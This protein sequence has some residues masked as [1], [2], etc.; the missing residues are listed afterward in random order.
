LMDRDSIR[1][2]GALAIGPAVEEAARVEPLRRRRIGVE[3]MPA[4]EMI[5]DAPL[6]IDPVQE[7]RHQG[8][9]EAERD[10]QEEEEGAEP[11]Q[12]GSH[13]SSP[14]VTDTGLGTTKPPP[15]FVRL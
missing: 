8:R 15:H 14:S 6:I 3:E 5:A 2:G 7:R 1:P 4:V 13:P 12:E 9:R 11:A 10:E